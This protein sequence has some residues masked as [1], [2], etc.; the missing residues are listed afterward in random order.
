METIRM[1]K[2]GVKTAKPVA[3]GGSG[4][5]QTAGQE[6]WYKREW[7][8]ITL[9]SIMIAA[10]V[11]RIIFAFGVSAGN[12]FALSG[13]SGASS[14]VH[15]IESILNGTFGFTDHS[16]NYPEGS[17]SIT[18]P[19]MGFILS[20]FAG[21]ATMMGV[22]AGTAAQATLA[23][24]APVFATLTCWPVFLIGR[25][26]FKDDKIG[27]LAALLYAFFA[28]MITT[29]VFSNGTEIAFVGFLF[30]FMIYFLLKAVEK[31]DTLEPA[32]FGGVFKDKGMLINLL[33]AGLLFAMI[34][35]SWNQFR[36][37]LLMLIVLMVAQAVIDRLKAKP[38]AP[39]VGIYSAIILLGMLISLP[40]YL[41]AGLWDLI[42]SGPFVTAL[43]SVGLAFFFSVTAKKTWV[44][45]VPITLAIAVAALVA[46]WLFSGDLFSAVMNGN[47][48]YE[49]ELMKNLVSGINRT[50]ISL[51]AA[52]FGWLTVWMPLLL[53]L[54]MVYKFRKN[55]DS[56]KFIFT[57][58]FVFF[59]FCIGW[60]STSYAAIAGSGFA[61]ASAALIL[62]VIREAKLKDYFEEMRGNGIKHALRKALKPIPLAATVG[63]VVLILVPN[64]IGAVDASMPTNNSDGNGYFGGLGYTIMTDDINAINKMWNEYNDVDKKGALVTWMG[65]SVNA[66]SNGGFQSVTDQFG[67]GTSTMSAVLLASSSSAATAAFA[68]RLMLANDV[69]SFRTAITAAGLDYD[70]VS[71]YINKPSTAVKE[72][73]DNKDKYPGINHGVTEEN[74]LYIVLANYMM[75]T[76]SEKKINDLYGSIRSTSGSSINYVSVDR[77]MLPLYY[78]DGSYFN[79]VAYLGSFALDGYGAP[80]NFYSYDTYSGYA[81]YKD[82]MFE[83]FFWKALIGMSPA[84]AG[85]SSS[86]EYLNALALSDGKIKANPGYGLAN[87]KIAYWHVYYNPDSKATVQNDGWEEMDAFEAIRLQNENGGVINFVNGVVLLEY[88]PT[89]T[90]GVSGVVNYKSSSGTAGAPG[91]QVSVFEK[92][93][94]DSS[95]AT[96]YVKKSTVFTD[97]NGE[98]TILVPVSGDYRVVYSSGTTTTAT[99][100]IIDTRTDVKT[101]NPP[102]EIPDTKLLGSIV[103]STD[104][105]KEEVFVSIE[106]K[107]SGLKRE[108]RTG[109]GTFVFN[110]IIPDIYV[111]TVYSP[112]GTTINTATVTVN[113]GENNGYRLSAT[114][115]T[116]NVTITTDLGASLPKGT[117]VTAQDTKTGATFIGEVGEDG[118]A[119]ILVV[120]STYIVYASGPSYITVNNPTSTVSNNGSSNASLTVYQ[121]RNITVSGA[122]SGSTV[123]LM[124]YGFITSSTS[125]TL[126]VPVC[127]GIANASYTAYAVSGGNVFYGMTTTNSLTLT[128]SAG[129]NISGK[130]KDS[131]GKA[132]PATV[133][134]IRSSGETFIFSSNSDGEF[135][136]KLPEGTYTMYIFSSSGALIKTYT[137]SGNDDLGDIKTEKSRTLTTTLNF[138]TNM[139]STSTRGVAFVDVNMAMT[140]DGIEYNIKTKTDSNGRAAFVVPQGYAAKMTTAKIDTSVFFM[141]DKSYDMATGK[142]DASYT[143]SINASK[144]DSNPD[145]VKTVS[146]T[147]PTP[148]ELR[149]YTSSS[150]SDP[151]KVSGSPVQIAPGEYNGYVNTGSTYFEG[152]IYIYPGKGGALDF[153]TMNVVMITLDAETTDN[154][155][156]TKVDGGEYFQDKTNTLIYYLERG[157][158]F[159]FTAT[160][161]SLGGD[162]KIAYASV[163]SASSPAT[164]NLK[165]KASKAVISGYVGVA[166]SGELLVTYGTTTIPFPIS[167]GTFEITVPAGKTLSLSAKVSQT[168]SGFEY[169]YTGTAT[170]DSAKVV[171]KAKINFPVTTVA[172][173]PPAPVVPELKGTNF[174]FNDGKG[175]FTLSVENKGDFPVTY[176]ITAGSAWT[177]DKGYTL[178]VDK[179]ATRTIEISGTYNPALVGAGD[180][181]L[182]VIVRSINGDTLGVYVLDGSAFPPSASPTQVIIDRSSAVDAFADAMNSYEYMFA[183]TVTNKDSFQKVA[184][185][186]LNGTV[187]SDWTVIFSDKD[188]GWIY[189]VTGTNSF[190][191]NGFSS[192][193]I[194]VKLMKK[195]GDYKDANVPN[196]EVAV[197]VKDLKGNA[198]SVNSNSEDVV[199][200][201]TSVTIKNMKADLSNVKIQ[202]ENMSA[203]GNNIFNDPSPVPLIT[204]VLMALLI[205]FVVL[206][207]WQGFKKG[208]FVR[209]R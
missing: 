141:E 142:T 61:L 82:G 184:T 64:A 46:L 152:K 104:L 121:T 200:T 180:E 202:A 176:T 189:P 62:L 50:S 7:R 54:F 59:M 2:S 140:I 107:A 159:Y 172:S 44:L 126:S 55:A 35:L 8:L 119:K 151:I 117:K 51:M 79:S 125:S 85:F 3:Y 161:A 70:I 71:G 49:S 179:G 97:K 197:T 168:I 67:N 137:V 73:R 68:I 48:V 98:Y 115:G 206:M 13:G 134:F 123:A 27:L 41:T 190:T 74:A 38:V 112:D 147:S 163:T 34:A 195:D 12:D 83:T 193:V 130:V 173:P 133:S 145:H 204:L 185:I 94:Y 36:I 122:P 21:L 156:V 24:A 65:N 37:I 199:L 56:R 108:I 186:T 30:A 157:K 32:G 58:W 148:I 194:Y 29:T 4:S 124:S 18:P 181:N 52:F 129:Y 63:M 19:L 60:Y 138:R 101:T 136:V 201:A 209:K 105:Y 5:V 120:P 169:K 146:V 187:S 160:E 1:R 158:S 188:G 162:G 99:G 128:S 75:D 78:N 109:S 167:D 149:L 150:T 88:D 198:M 33:A 31:C 91:I 6:K 100:Y 9:L 139:S 196:I 135:S 132:M 39:V 110:N 102:V 22:S 17:V 45:M 96:Q 57:M 80:I 69:S 144:T 177:L 43:L 116:I 208:V 153:K 26:M 92:V 66:A 174:S 42:F 84:E 166:A 182:S 86:F 205:L 53:F 72:I 131:D 164:L 170:M 15:I 76:I 192:T 191:V 171:D 183:V 118:K 40:Y 113:I 155:T 20:A 165:D 77:N 16:L 90:T 111:V 25:N 89:L 47:S 114:S 23:F 127:G 103:V 95:G 93:N 203:S 10:F 143:W 81:M 14:Q 154:I 87:Y 106:G 11:I 178:T 207:M 28:L 175:K